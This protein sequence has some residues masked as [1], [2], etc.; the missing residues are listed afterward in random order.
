M[1]PPKIFR[2]VILGFRTRG[3]RDEV[4]GGGEGRS[5]TVEGSR[6]FE[7]FEGRGSRDSHPG[8]R[9]GSRGSSSRDSHPNSVE[10]TIF[11]QFAFSL[12][13]GTVTRTP[14][15]PL[16]ADPA[17]CHNLGSATHRARG[18]GG[19]PAPH[20]PAGQQP[21]TN[22]LQ[23]PGSSP[24]PHAPPPSRRVV[25]PAGARLVPDAEP[26]PPGRHPRA[27]AFAGPRSGPRGSRD[28]HLNSA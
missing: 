11:Q 7:G 10:V 8:V 15:E 21:P 16:T 25:R 22:L 18:R 14:P 12:N 28:R 17:I 2:P 19:R 1:R 20:H 6:G 26:R 9:G 3:S 13:Q 24:L 23:R 27:R 4:R 5:R